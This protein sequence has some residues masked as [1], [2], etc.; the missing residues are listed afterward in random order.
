MLTTYE[1]YTNSKPIYLAV[2]ILKIADDLQVDKMTCGK[3][4]DHPD[5][6]QVYL[7]PEG[8]MIE[9]TGKVLPDGQMEATIHLI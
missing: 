3:N 1:V 6:V 9:M 2:D 8:A 5:R 4:P 7:K